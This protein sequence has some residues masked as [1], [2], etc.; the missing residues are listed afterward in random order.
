MNSVALARNAMASRFE[1]LIFGPDAARL[2]AAGEEALDE[3][4]RIDAQLSIYRSSSEI[5]H[6]NARASTEPVRLSPPVFALLV[7]ARQLWEETEGAFDI[8]M[9]PLMN[10]WGFMTNAPATPSR[11]ELDELLARVGMGHVEF[12]PTDCAIRFRRPGMMMDLGAIGKGHAV[13]QAVEILVE[14]GVQS[15]LLHGGTSTVYGLGVPP[16]GEGWRIAIEDPLE[17]FAASD[18]ESTILRLRGS[19]A[20][21]TGA[22]EKR[23][24]REVLLRDNALSVSSPG[25]KFFREG[26]AI[27]GHVLDPRTGEPSQLSAFAAVVAPSPTDSDA[28]STALLVLGPDEVARAKARRPEIE[29][30]VTLL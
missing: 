28:F 27:R 1:L 16:E 18:A 9:G 11:S 7:R 12:L 23:V 25:G 17:A 20:Q 14:A 13:E 30:F 22:A 21:P 6:V 10:A 5:S 4:E 15:A 29:A 3:I 2:R 24:V 26:T 8:T 19:D